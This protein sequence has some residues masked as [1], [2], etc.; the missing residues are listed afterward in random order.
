[1][2]REVTVDG[3]KIRYLE[4]GTG[5]PVVM[6]HGATDWL[7]R[8]DM[9]AVTRRDIGD[10]GVGDVL[11]SLAAN[12]SDAMLPGY[13]YGL[14]Y[15]DRHAQVSNDEGIVVAGRLMDVLAKAPRRFAS[16]NTQ[17]VYLNEVTG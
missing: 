14:S 5:L 13:P 11:A 17:H 3:L 6:L 7:Y 2:E 10:D 8:L 15:A 1:M 16:L 4:E 9:D 12:S